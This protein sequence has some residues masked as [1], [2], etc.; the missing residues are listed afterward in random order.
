MEF[1]AP[2]MQPV[3]SRIVLLPQEGAESGGNEPAAQL[4]GGARGWDHAARRRAL[5][6]G[7]AG[8]RGVARR[9]PSRREAMVLSHRDVVRS[10][11][12]FDRLP[13]LPMLLHPDDQDSEEARALGLE[14][15]DPMSHASLAKFDAEGDPCSRAFRRGP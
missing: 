11:D 8:H 14:F 15:A 7:D 2:E 10:G 1:Y 13:R 9:G 4:L 5:F 3:G 6:L 12:A